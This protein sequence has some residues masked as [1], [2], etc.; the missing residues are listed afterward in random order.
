MFRLRFALI[1][2]V[3]MQTEYRSTLGI[4]LPFC[5]RFSVANTGILSEFLCAFVET[6][7]I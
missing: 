5:F 6:I 4:V 2:L 1:R 3:N 7:A